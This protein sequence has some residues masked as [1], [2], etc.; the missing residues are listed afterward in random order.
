M[1]TLQSKGDRNRCTVTELLQTAGISRTE[2]YVYYKNIA[3]FR[4][5]FYRT[6]FSLAYCISTAFSAIPRATGNRTWQTREKSV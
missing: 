2:F 6:V 1:T 5:K 3:D 4:D